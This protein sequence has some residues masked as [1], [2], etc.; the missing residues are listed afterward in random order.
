MAQL[1]ISPFFWFEKRFFLIPKEDLKTLSTKHRQRHDWCFFLNS[2]R[3]DCLMSVGHFRNWRSTFTSTPMRIRKGS[4]FSSS[5][6]PPEISQKPPRHPQNSWPLGVIIQPK[7]HSKNQPKT[8]VSCIIFPTEAR[9]QPS[10]INQQQLPPQVLGPKVAGPP[11]T[12]AA[13]HGLDLQW[14][15]LLQELGKLRFFF[16][17]FETKD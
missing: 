15:R 11:T 1:N 4:T 8:L 7:K 2:P 16:F 13:W 3:W 14:S 9:K 12:S 17:F 5:E 6:V 10:I